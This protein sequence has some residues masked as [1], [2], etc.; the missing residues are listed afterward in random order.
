MNRR[1]LIAALLSVLLLMFA[2]PAVAGLSP[3]LS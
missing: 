3:A 2:L 1:H